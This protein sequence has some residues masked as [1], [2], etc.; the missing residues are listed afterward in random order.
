[1]YYNL[2]QSRY[3][4]SSSKATKCR[5][6]H[7]YRGMYLRHGRSMQDAMRS[8][9]GPIYMK[10]E[11]GE[12][13]EREGTFGRRRAEQG[14]GKQSQIN[15]YFHSGF[16]DFWDLSPSIRILE[17]SSSKIQEKGTGDHISKQRAKKGEGHYGWNERNNKR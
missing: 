14:E 9:Y 5:Y 10:R 16:R 2:A 17:S 6:L 11:G 8:Y 7:K 13:R 12:G 4:Q 3:V 1:M 15:P